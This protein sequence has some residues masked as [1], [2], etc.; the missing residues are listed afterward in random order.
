MTPH[1]REVDRAPWVSG[2]YWAEKFPSQVALFSLTADQ[3]DKIATLCDDL[4]FR[5]LRRLDGLDK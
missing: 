5:I 1:P 2:V 4:I 3:K